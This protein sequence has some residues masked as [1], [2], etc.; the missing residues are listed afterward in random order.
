MM[1]VGFIT[2]GRTN[3]ATRVRVAGYLPGLAVAGIETR[4]LKW[5]PRRRLDVAMLTSRAV[6]L[7]RW[8]DVVVL[9]KPRQPVQVLDV[10]TRVNP[11]LVVDLDDALWTWGPTVSR[12]FDHAVA[13]ASAVV[14]GSEYLAEHVR[15]RQPGVPVTVIPSSVGLDRYRIRAPRPPGDPPVVG[16]IG[17][18]GSLTD[19]GPGVLSALRGLCAE[20]RARVRI[21]CD[22]PLEAD[23]LSAEFEPWSESGEVDALGVFDVGIAPLRDDERSRGRCSFKVVQCMAVGVPVIASPVGGVCEVVRDR[24]TGLLASTFAEWESRITELLTDQALADGLASAARAAV[25][26]R[27]S[28]EANLPRL[29]S[30]LDGSGNE[31]R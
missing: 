24:E 10:V 8:A 29:I 19:F 1:R 9:Q 22:Q 30:V 11:N 3:A 5:A 12:R 26:S 17:T 4:E 2:R 21:I 15:R 31:G 14:A 13:R 25:E 16:W 7:A 6:A 23:G 20:G 27:F 18:G 28:V